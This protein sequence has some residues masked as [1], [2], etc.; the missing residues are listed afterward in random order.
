[1]KHTCRLLALALS[2][3]ADGDARYMT[4]LVAYLGEERGHEEWILDDLASLGGDP[5]RVAA[6]EGALPTRAMVA[7]VH[8]AILHDSPYAMLGMVH[9]LEGLS[10]A[11]ASTAARAFGAADGAGFSYLRSHGEFDQRHVAFF[12]ELV[13]GI[14]DPAAR[15][16]VVETARAVYRLY[17]DIFREIDAAS[18]ARRAT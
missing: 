17:G 2:R 13:Y 6:G 18:G 14:D 7:Y 3:C 12:C 11:F 16:A 15:R 1:V 8:Y 10:A 5:A 4:A 9:V